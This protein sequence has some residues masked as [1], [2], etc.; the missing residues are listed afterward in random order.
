MA[1]ILGLAFLVPGILWLL[2][3]RWFDTTEASEAKQSQSLIEPEPLAE[4]SF[5]PAS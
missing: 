1:T 4:T 3:Q 5:P 2:I